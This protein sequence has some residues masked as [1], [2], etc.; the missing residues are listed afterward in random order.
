MEPVPCSRQSSCANLT[1]HGYQQA[2]CTVD[3]CTCS[4]YFTDSTGQTIECLVPTPP[5]KTIL[6]FSYEQD[7]PDGL[8]A[9]ISDS[10][11]TPSTVYLEGEATVGRCQLLQKH[12]KK[13]N[14]KVYM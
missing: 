12:L 10:Q 11:E 13:T 7:L 2:I 6:A 5:P 1:C 9:E 3:P 8:S 4:P 14:N